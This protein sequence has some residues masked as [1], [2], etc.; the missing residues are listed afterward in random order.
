MKTLIALSVG[1]ASASL[2]GAS[3]MNFNRIASFATAHNI[4]S[5]MD[6]NSE[7]SA[8]IISASD[9]GMTLIYSDSPMGGVG[10][11]DIRDPR[12]PKAAGFVALDGEPTAVTVKGN[13]ALI[14]VNTSADYINT[15]GKLVQ[16]DLDSKAVTVVCE[17]TGQPDSVA[18]SPDGTYAAV[19]IENERD[20]DLNGGAIPQMP[21]GFVSVFSIRQGA[22]DC[23]SQRDIALTGLAGVAPSDPEAEFVDINANNEIVVSLQENNHLVIAS[24]ATGQVIHHFSAG[25]VDLENVDVDEERALTFDGTLTQVP[26][27]PDAVKWLDNDRFVTANE[28]DYQGGSRGF[29]IF[30]KAGELLFDSGISFDHLTAT[31]GHYPEKRSGNKGAEPEGLEVAT[32][33][34]VRYI[35]VMSERGSLIAAYEDTGREPR[36]LQT[37]PSGIS[38][39]SAIAIPGRNL[40]ASANEVDLVEDGGARA[41]VMIFERSQSAANYPHI[42]SVMRDGRPI[43]WGALS[44]LAADPTDAGVL[45]AVNDSFYGLQPQIFTIDARQHPAKIVSSVTVNRAGITAAKLDLEGIAADGQGGFWLASEGRPERLIP[46]ALYQVDSNGE[47]QQEIAFPPALQQVSKRWAAEGITLIGDR[48]WIAIQRQWLDDPIDTVKLVSY[49]LTDQSWGAVHYPTEK[50]PKGW[51]GLSEISAHGSDIY[52]IERD[53]QIGENAA[54]KRLYKVAQADLKPVELGGTLPLVSKTLVRD[55]IPDLKATGGYV[56]DKIEGFAI[57]AAGQGYAVTDNDGVDDSSGETLFF[58]A[59]RY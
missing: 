46:H 31:L 32:F 3:D 1:I 29:S 11:V 43:G 7:S 6:R 53:N 52:L 28:G 26:R 16:L 45:Y 14:G 30:N 50:A 8:E 57:D 25:A 17:L 20:E 48:L 51:V 23:D 40:L 5:N 34:G 18:I 39:E 54:I 33:D 38:P 42:E 9:D 37:L 21:A 56:V 13:R 36:L 59:G 27:E 24:A 2:A 44:G 55:F 49:N 4:P 47:I 41:H 35:F 15:S 12:A 19:A 10:M 22:L 58:K